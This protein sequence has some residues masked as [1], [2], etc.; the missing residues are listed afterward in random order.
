M[1]RLLM[2]A[3][4]TLMVPGF[5]SRS[6]AAQFGRVER[7]RVCFYQDIHYRGWE[8]CFSPGDELS[9][10]NRDKNSISS[11]R[12]YGRARVVVFDNENFNGNAAEFANDVP[13][14][15]LRSMNGSRTWNDRI[16]SLRVV[17][18][19]VSNTRFPAPR[20]DNDDRD[21]RDG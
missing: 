10:L 6:E 11:I 3:A 19:G 18:F 5:L 13:D 20:R 15:A 2:I 21:G 9:D 4:A 17:G 1:K 7:D 12:V 16:E 14:L 8:K